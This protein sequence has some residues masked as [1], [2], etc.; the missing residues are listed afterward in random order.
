[1]TPSEHRHSTP[2]RIRLRRAYDAPGPDDG[3]RILVDRLWPRGRSREAMQLDSWLKEVAPSTE[4]RRW[5]GHDPARWP[6][7]QRR[8]RQEI[9]ANPAALAPLVDAAQAGPLTLVYAARDEARN[10]AVVLRELL[11]EYLS[12]AAG[13]SA[14]DVVG[15]ASFDSFPASDAPGWATGRRRPTDWAGEADPSSGKDGTS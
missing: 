9:H 8:Y 5:F 15:Q 3:R 13:G 14:R 1:M 10:E 7:F 4:L 6:E 2:P 11:L 12:T